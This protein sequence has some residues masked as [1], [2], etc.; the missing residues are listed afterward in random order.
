MVLRALGLHRAPGGGDEL[1]AAVPARS[2][3]A[4]AAP[5]PPATGLGVA[6]LLAGLGVYG[7]ATY[8]GAGDL[9]VLSLV[10]NA[11]ACAALWKG[12]GALRVVALPVAFLLFAMPL[13][14]PLLNELV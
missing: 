9:Q 7:W 4:G 3:T 14:G 8:T 2:A 11:L 10:F 5:R 13:P 12:S 6:L 1:V